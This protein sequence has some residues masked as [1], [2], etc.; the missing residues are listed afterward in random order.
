[1][2]EHLDLNMPNVNH[3]EI[4][5]FASEDDANYQMVSGWLEKITADLW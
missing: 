2:F 4:C 1:M 3:V 5:K